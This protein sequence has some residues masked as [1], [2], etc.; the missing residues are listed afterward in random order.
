MRTELNIALKKNLELRLKLDQLEQD[1]E[2]DLQASL[3]EFGEQMAQK[4][5]EASDPFQIEKVLS[6][7]YDQIDSIKG[8]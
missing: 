3:I 1:Q 7:A 4:I 6:S 2:L 5:K 8:G